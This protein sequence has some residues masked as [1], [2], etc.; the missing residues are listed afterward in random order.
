VSAKPRAEVHQAIDHFHT[1]FLARNREKP[2]ITGKDA[3]LAKQLVTRHGLEKVKEVMEAMLDSLDPFISQS[4][5][6]FGLLSSQ[7]NKLVQAPR[8]GALLTDQTRRNLQAVQEAL[9]AGRARED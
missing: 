7:W 4:G 8:R 1:I 9:R 2:H 3:A 5:P 6:S